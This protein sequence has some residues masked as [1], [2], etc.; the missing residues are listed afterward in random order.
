[1]ASDDLDVTTRD[2]LNRQIEISIRESVVRSREKV[3][4]DLAAERR[5]AIGRERM[6]LNDDLQRREDR[7]KQLTDRYNALVTEGIRV[8]YQRPTTRFMEA[9]REVALEIA[10]E[11]SNIYA[12][13]PVPMTARVIGRTAP[14]VARMLDY[15]AENTRV[16]RDMQ[17]G[18]MDALHLVDVAGIPFVD[19]PPIYYPS[20]ERWRELTRMRQKYK[21]V[22]LANPGSTEKRI[23]E[24][25]EKPVENF[26]FTETPLRDVIAQI[27]DAQGIPVEIDSKAFEDA[28][29]DLET[30]VTKSVSGISLR[31][32]LRLLLGDLDL[33][34]LIKDEVLLITTKDKAAENLVVK[35]YPVADLVLP[36]NPSSGMNPFQTGGGMG[37]AGGVNSGQGA[38]GGMGGGGMGG[39]MFQISEA[40]A[41]LA[42]RE[43]PAAVPPASRD[44]GAG[45]S[46]GAPTASAAA[47][48]P[49]AQTANAG[50]PA[51]GPGADLGLPAD[52]VAAEDLQTAVGVYLKSDPAARMARLRVT[53]AELGR[54][55][56][57][58]RAADLIAAALA[59]GHGEHWMYE[60]L[61]VAMEAAGRSR[62]DIERAL[63]SGADFAT[64]PV[65]LLALAHHLARFGS[66]RRA[67]RLCRQAATLDPTNRE[68]FALAMSLAA[69]T[70]D[71]D[72]LRWACPGVLRHEWP[73]DQQEIPTR[74]ARLSKTSIEQFEKDGRAAEA[75]A[76]RSAVDEALVRDI[77]L[78]FSWNG[79]ADIDLIVEEPPG[80]VCSPSAPR[81]TSGGT[82]IAD[83]DAPADPANATQRER[84]VATEAFPGTYRILVRRAW[85]K[86]AAT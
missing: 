43:K 67:V 25:L 56:R 13:Y 46:L 7:I 5:A 4:R 68:A 22:D 52:I 63:L 76:F 30:P 37:G 85:G 60:A 64:T 38:G 42:R 3:E 65:D 48:S 27:E 77:D 81:S 39:G 66:D 73:A 2:R 24:A 69:R 57:F 70:N 82:L 20:A 21:S 78:Q 10:E 33:T 28:G 49:A 15:D 71:L 8:G 58:D 32:A 75:T 55:G 51:A 18:F 26:D 17:R 72:T 45:L 79:D 9:E 12:N 14:L 44:D 80:T 53:A 86:V 35:V 54:Q 6:R 1:M 23:Y 40:R 62:E 41:R 31:S 84:Y 50:E 47:S 19:E 83:A 16:R 36:V 29:L 61:A 11:A 59:G 34:Y 74:A